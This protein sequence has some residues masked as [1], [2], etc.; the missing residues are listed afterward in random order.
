MQYDGNVV[1]SVSLDGVVRATRCEP[2]S[3]TNPHIDARANINT[4]TLVNSGRLQTTSEDEIDV[5][6]HA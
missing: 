5:G 3:Q 2:H 1:E 6:A 4:N